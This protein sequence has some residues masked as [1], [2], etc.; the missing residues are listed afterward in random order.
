MAVAVFYALPT[1]LEF[2]IIRHSNLWLA[3]I[4][5]GD[6]SGC[7]GIFVILKKRKLAVLLYLALTALEFWLYS[8]RILSAHTLV[9]LMDLVPTV[10]VASAML[11]PRARLEAFRP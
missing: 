2:A 1:L 4:L 9:Y 10:I 5:V 8:T 7:I 3:G 11:R 6:L